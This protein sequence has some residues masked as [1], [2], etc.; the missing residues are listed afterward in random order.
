MSREAYLLRQKNMEDDTETS[1]EARSQ[2]A[3]LQ[4]QYSTATNDLTSFLVG[5]H[6]AVAHVE[7]PYI[8]LYPTQYKYPPMCQCTYTWRMPI[9]IL[10]F[11]SKFETPEVKTP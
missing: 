8:P 10:L 11:P 9:Q 5:W 3:R 1:N 7:Q 2:E 6:V 4:I